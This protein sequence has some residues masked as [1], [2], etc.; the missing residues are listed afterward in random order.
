VPLPSFFDRFL[1]FS[2]ARKV[3][4]IYG[5]L[6]LAGDYTTKDSG[7]EGLIEAQRRCSVS[8]NPFTRVVGS[9]CLAAV[10]KERLLLLSDDAI[11]QLFFDHVWNVIDVLS[12]ELTICQV[13][14][15]R[16]IN[17]SSVV[18]TEKENANQ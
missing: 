9:L 16:L 12:P 15:E 5:G 1:P 11:G 7:V 14:T 13:A 4:Q 10:L 8:R 2:E 3:E 6:S 18:K 17:S